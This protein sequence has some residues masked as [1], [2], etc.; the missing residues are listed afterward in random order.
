MSD[1]CGRVLTD[2]ILSSYPNYSTKVVEVGS[3]RY[4]AV[5]LALHS[6]YDVTATDILE[7]N[8]V[9]SRLKP[10]YIKDDVTRPDLG[11]YRGARLIYSIRPPIEIQPY[12]LKLSERVGADMLIKPLGSEILSDTRLSLINL[13]GKAIYVLQ[14]DK[15]TG[16]LVSVQ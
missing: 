12:I 5:A 14:R 8:A 11:L 7:T 15:L 13:R 9:D 1:S 3:G 2:F 4:S 16:P 10:L 6:H